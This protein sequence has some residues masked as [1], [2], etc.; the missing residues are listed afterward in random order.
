VGSR[1]LEQLGGDESAFLEGDIGGGLVIQRQ[2]SILKGN[3]KI[4][5]IDSSIQARSVGPGSG[6][7]S[8]RVVECLFYQKI[9]SDNHKLFHIQHNIYTG[10]VIF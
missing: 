2:I 6:G 9:T 3:P 1:P 5:Q 8:R 7:F 4:L 10:E